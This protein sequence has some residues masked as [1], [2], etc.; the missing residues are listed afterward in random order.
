MRMYRFRLY[1]SKAQEKQMNTNF[2]LAKN[3]WNDLLEH[4]KTIYQNFDKFPTKSTIAAMTKDSGLYSQVAQEIGSRVE[5]GIWRY[6]KLRKS[7]N[8]KAGFPRFKSIDRMKSLD[9][10]QFGFSIGKKLKVTPFGEI[11]IV[12]HRE[13]KGK[14]KTLTLKKE[15][16]GKW[17]ACFAVEK[18]PTTRASNGKPTVGIDFGLK[19]PATLSDGNVIKNPRHMKKHAD[20]LARLQQFLSRKKKDSKNRRDAKREV[21][22]VYEKIANTRADFLHKATISLVNSYSLIAMEKLASQE[23]S[24][25]NF[26]KSINDAGWRMFA[27]M[28]R[29]KAESAGC[30]V[31]FVNPENTT[32]MC[33]KCGGL[34]GMPLEV[35]VYECPCGNV[36]NRDLNAAHNIL[37]R[38]TQGH[39]GSNASGDV[40]QGTSL[41]EEAHAL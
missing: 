11:S 40:Q 3:L 14:I 19:T 39:W 38:A 41:K 29:Y 31:V 21:A 2:W 17:F 28:L 35:R 23:M 4:S 20:R 33:S 12:Q 22:I 9:Y 34:Q 18:T 27:N 10:P 30:Q 13:I 25:Q 1:P 24:E 7:G 16:S 5:N 36:M 26:G 15:A 37:T 32:K 8:G 6:V